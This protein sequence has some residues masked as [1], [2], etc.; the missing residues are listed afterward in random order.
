MNYHIRYG[1]SS[2]NVWNTQLLFSLL[3]YMANVCFKFEEVVIYEDP[4]YVCA[5]QLN[6]TFIPGH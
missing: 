4:N 1:I 3:E 6:I 5:Y 2:C